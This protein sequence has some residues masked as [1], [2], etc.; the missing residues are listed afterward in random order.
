MNARP[1][2]LVTVLSLVLDTS[3]SKLQRWKK[4][5]TAKKIDNSPEEFSR[6]LHYNLAAGHKNVGVDQ[7]GA[8]KRL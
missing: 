3:C 7:K 1:E 2:C 8:G 5:K 4:L 6:Y